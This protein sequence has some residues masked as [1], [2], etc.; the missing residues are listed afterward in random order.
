MSER[1]SLGQLIDNGIGLRISRVIIMSIPVVGTLIVGMAAYSFNLTVERF[2]EKLDNLN[3]N[4]EQLN[5]TVGTMRNEIVCQLSR[6]DR[7]YT[8]EYG[9]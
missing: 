3:S 7:S 1:K 2:T 5:G 9:D 6:S 8:N 4:L